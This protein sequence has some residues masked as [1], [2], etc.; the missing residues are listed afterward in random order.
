MLLIH[1]FVTDQTTDSRHAANARDLNAFVARLGGPEAVSAGAIA[2]PFTFP[3]SAIFLH[4]S[5]SMW[6][7][8]YAA[9]AHR[10]LD[11]RIVLMHVSVLST[12]VI[13]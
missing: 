2:G 1:E 13:N 10:M 5:L 8:P 12:W 4:R 3:S 9:R 7:R 11:M 6:G